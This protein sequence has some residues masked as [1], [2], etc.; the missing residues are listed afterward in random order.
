MVQGVEMVLPL[1]AVEMVPDLLTDHGVTV[2]LVVLAAVPPGVAT[3]ICPVLA[4]V[5]T[6]AVI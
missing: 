1:S 2:K 4:P 5:G 3:W 6:V